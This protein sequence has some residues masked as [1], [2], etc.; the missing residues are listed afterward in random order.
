MTATETDYMHQYA[1]LRSQ[2]AGLQALADEHFG[3]DPDALNW[4]HVGDLI[5]LQNILAEAIAI[6]AS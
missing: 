3:N 2:I 5:R 1:Y 4:A 6:A